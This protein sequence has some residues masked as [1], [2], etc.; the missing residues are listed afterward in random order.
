MPERRL[1]D[2]WK[3]VVPSPLGPAIVSSAWAGAFP[4]TII[5]ALAPA[6][7]PDSQRPITTRML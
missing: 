7:L 3:S 6:D 1:P 4:V 2:A 5:Q